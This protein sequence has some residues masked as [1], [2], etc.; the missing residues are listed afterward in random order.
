MADFSATHPEMTAFYIGIASRTNNGNEVRTMRGFN[1]DGAV[2]PGGLASALFLPAPHMMP[3]FVR[4]T[5]AGTTVSSMRIAYAPFQGQNVN[6]GTLL[7]VL[8]P[9]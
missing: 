6:A 7:S 1:L 8:T 4:F 5:A 3:F 2:A 9:F